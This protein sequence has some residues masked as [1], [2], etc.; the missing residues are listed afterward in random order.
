MQYMQYILAAHSSYLL[1]TKKKILLP[2]YKNKIQTECLFELFLN[3][4]FYIY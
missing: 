2:N 1:N 3:F 4:F